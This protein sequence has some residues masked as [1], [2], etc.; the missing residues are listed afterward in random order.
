MRRLRRDLFPSAIHLL[1][2]WHLQRRLARALGQEAQEQIAYLANLARLGK[3]DDLLAALA[4]LRPQ[5]DP[6]DPRRQFI[7]DLIVY[8]EANSQGIANYA[9]YGPQASGAIEKVMDVSVGRRL[10]AKGTSWYRN[11]AH[12]LLALPTLKQNGL[13]NSY[14][15]ARRARTP[16]LA[17]WHRDPMPCQSVGCFPHNSRCFQ[18][19]RTIR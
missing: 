11:G 8:V 15:Q 19:G 5:L 10:K 16:L 18:S 9:L 4:Q 13:W 12:H 14:W 1:D 7:D 6:E 3:V 17:L 2:I